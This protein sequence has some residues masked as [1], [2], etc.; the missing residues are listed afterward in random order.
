[1]TP[2]FNNRQQLQY[3]KTDFNAHRICHLPGIFRCAKC[4]KNNSTSP[5]AALFQQCLFCGMPNYIKMDA[6]KSPPNLAHSK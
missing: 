4:K 6:A 1:M 2:K 3:Q 5:G